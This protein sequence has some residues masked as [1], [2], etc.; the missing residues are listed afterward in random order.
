MSTSKKKAEEKVKE[1]QLEEL[2]D[3]KIVTKGTRNY[4]DVFQIWR[5]AGCPQI[6]MV[7]TGR[8]TGKTTS[9]AVGIADYCY[10][11]HKQ[12]ILISRDAFKQ[13][14]RKAWFHNVVTRGLTPYDIICDMNTFKI[15]GQVIGYNYS[16]HAY[17][18]YRSIEFPEVDF[19]IFDEFIELEPSNYWNDNGVSEAQFL[20][21]LVSTI[22]RDRTDGACFL[23]G[24]NMNEDSKYNPYFEAF[25]IDFDEMEIEIGNLY[26]IRNDGHLHVCLYYGGMGREGEFSEVQGWTAWM[27]LN[28][29]ALSGEFAPNPLILSNFLHNN[30]IDLSDMKPDGAGLALCTQGVIEYVT[31]YTYKDEEYHIVSRKAFSNTDYEPYRIKTKA[32]CQRFLL[33]HEA[34]LLYESA[35]DYATIRKATDVDRISILENQRNLGNYNKL[36]ETDM[37]CLTEDI[38]IR[39]RR[40]FD[41][42]TWNLL[43]TEHPDKE[44]YLVR[45]EELNYPINEDWIKFSINRYEKL[46]TDAS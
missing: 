4:L 5:D 33:N 6:L 37:G 8:G 13:V 19:I 11:N 18:D 17:N 21:D 46:L 41:K 44:T 43:R 35:K 9:C 28:D 45:I 1:K 2:V 42:W 32:Q 36:L 26:H 15:D 7:M 27:P 34:K 23:L 40:D 39:S 22:F 20:S 16:L 14:R 29:V 38:K 30:D 31:Y 24:N 25:G 12:F 3:D 10:K